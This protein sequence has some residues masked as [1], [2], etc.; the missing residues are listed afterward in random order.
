MFQG[1]RFEDLKV[2]DVDRLVNASPAN[3]QKGARIHEVLGAMLDHPASRKVYVIDVEG[4]LAGVIKT[5]TLL[6]LIGYRVGV[7]ENTALS[8]LKMLKDMQKES[9]ESVME[10]VRPVK[11]MTPLK[12][13]VELMVEDR[14]NDLPV[15]DD[16]YKLIGELTTLELFQAAHDLFDK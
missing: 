8:F 13:A 9:A 3:V 6:K 15:V 10:K 16:D 7:R 1:K 5:E 11:R 4:N 14:V 12:D 2:E